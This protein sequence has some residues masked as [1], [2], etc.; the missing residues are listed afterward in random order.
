MHTLV[1]PHTM[2][3]SWGDQNPTTCVLNL[4]SP[5]VTSG[6]LLGQHLHLGLVR[7]GQATVGEGAVGGMTWDP[8]P[9]HSPDQALGW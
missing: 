3:K 1:A 8:G 5:C 6:L 9:F 2:F 7:P 4:L